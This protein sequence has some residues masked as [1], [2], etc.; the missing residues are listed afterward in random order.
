MRR[1]RCSWLIEQNG[2]ASA[3]LREI[4]AADRRSRDGRL[5]DRSKTWPV[6]TSR[7]EIAVRLQAFLPFVT[8]PD[9]NVDAAAAHAVA[10]A[11]RIGADIRALAINVDIPDISNA[12]SKL[13]ID[14]PAMIRQ[15]EAASRER[16]KRLLA[17]VTEKAA[18][19]GVAT[20]TDT[21]TA[22]LA[23]LGDAAATQARYFDLSL[24][25]W[26]MSNTTS[27]MTAEA[28][29]FGSG[30]PAI[31]LPETFEIA[32]VDHVAVAWDGSRVAARAVADA[33]PFLERAD[34]I[35]VITVADEKPLEEEDAGERLAGELTRRGLNAETVPAE[36]KGRPIGETLQQAATDRGCRL[37][38]MGG[39][40]H[41]RI[42]DFV[43]GG[44]TEGV[45]SELRM[46]V[47][48]SH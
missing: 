21:I 1:R 12:L 11:A 38:V 47:L 22:P 19:A 28:V 46:P 44:A 27:R 32:A 7:G 41:S 36:A 14:V 17:M 31:L 29:V 30:R 23:L 18:A 43:L 10:F 24:I 37:L 35:S 8:Y 3:F 9:A 33:R 48:L 34:R 6:P 2:K 4:K 26:E 42:R 39:Y 5:A 13:L 45:L 25:G 15:A 40:G 20:A 16:G